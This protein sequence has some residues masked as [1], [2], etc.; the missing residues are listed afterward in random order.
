VGLALVVPAEGLLLAGKEARLIVCG[1]RDYNHR[2]IVYSYLDGA[3]EKLGDCLVVISGGAPGAD[4]LAEEWARENDVPVRVF[5]ADWKT[6]G[7]RAGPIRN[8]RMLEEGQPNMVL[9]FPGGKGTED[10][11]SRAVKARVPVFRAE[12]TQ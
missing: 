9:A 6:H 2:E 10:M 11:I 8:Q 4:T 7:R 5:K 12:T 3:L 1:G